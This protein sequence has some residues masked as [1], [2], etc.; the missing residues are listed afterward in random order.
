MTNCNGRQGTS[1][2]L[3]RFKCGVP[4]KIRQ[5]C[6]QL[7][8]PLVWHLRNVELLTAYSD[9][10]HVRVMSIPSLKIPHDSQY[11]YCITRIPSC[12]G[13]D[14]VAARRSIRRRAHRREFKEH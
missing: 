5:T 11:T 2:T 14:V 10:Y 1:I 3:A 6:F 4:N 13:Q 9:G 7:L 12:S 8:I